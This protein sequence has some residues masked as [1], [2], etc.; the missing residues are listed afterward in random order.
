MA[1][2]K[3]L[4]AL[5]FWSGDAARAYELARYLADLEPHHNETADFMLCARKDC[6]LDRRVAFDVARKFNVTTFNSRRDGVGW[7]H[8]CNDLWFDTMSFIWENITTGKFP[9]YKAVLTFEADCVPLQKEWIARLHSAWD[10]RG[11]NEAIPVN[12]IGALQNY[13]SWHINGNAMFSAD[14]GYLKQIVRIGSC[15]PAHGWDYAIAPQLKKLGWKSVP[16]IRSIWNS[17]S[18]GPS[19]YAKFKNEQCALLHGVKDRSA[20][21]LSRQD[22]LGVP[23]PS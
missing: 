6:V 21:H 16:E 9:Q 14:L 13:P 23:L 17:K 2:K 10:R 11:H 15:N 8:G 5:Q 4:L 3:I 7:P 22:L 1:A 18:I 12:L 20:F 19:G